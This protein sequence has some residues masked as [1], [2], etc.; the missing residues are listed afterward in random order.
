MVRSFREGLRNGD[1]IARL[2]ARFVELPKD[3]HDYFERIIFQDV[4]ESYHSDSA[5]MFHVALG[6]AIRLP[7]F[8][9]WFIGER[10][11]DYH[12]SSPGVGKSKPLTPDKLKR[13]LE[14]GL[15]RLSACCKGL[16]ELQPQALD[17]LPL[18]TTASPPSFS[19]EVLLNLRVDF[20]HRTV[21]DF[22][23]TNETQ[24]VLQKWHSL[25]SHTSVYEMICEALLEQIRTVPTD[26][27]FWR[28]DD[29][30]WDLC[31]DFEKHSWRGREAAGGPGPDHDTL[32]GAVPS[33]CR[34]AEL[35][36]ALEAVLR[37][38]GADFTLKDIDRELDDFDG[39]DWTSDAGADSEEG[40]ESKQETAKGFL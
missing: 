16:L 36:K 26:P 18:A 11:T 10:G 40:V 8:V 12:V 13:R 4:S 3:L 20:L 1:S 30:V 23:L 28:K 5:D 7:L 31:L 14:I 35:R 25:P 29:I 38:V 32:P 21:H 6:A 19:H 27:K 22:L 15:K 17:H 33:F 24:K 37:S 34:L 39:S 2:R 9:Y